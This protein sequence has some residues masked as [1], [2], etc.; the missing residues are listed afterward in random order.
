MEHATPPVA[1]DE[2]LDPWARDRR[3][4]SIRVIPTAQ[5][6]EIARP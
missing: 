5:R 4:R 2:P 3:T 6:E 1:V